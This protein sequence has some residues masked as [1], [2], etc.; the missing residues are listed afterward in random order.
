LASIDI[1]INASNLK[2]G[3]GIQ[4]A[5]SFMSE[6]MKLKSYKFHFFLNRVVNNYFVDTESNNYEKYIIE[7]IPT[8]S[9]FSWIKFNKELNKLERLIDP[10]A[11]ITVFGSLAFHF[12]FRR[13]SGAEF[14]QVFIKEW[15][16]YFY[17]CSHAHFV[18]IIEIMVR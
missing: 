15:N 4:V 16:A 1:I 7:N 5:L 18:S 9:I 12:Q 13:Q 17:T 6:A 11:V 3:G 8:D 10:L 2:K 14:N